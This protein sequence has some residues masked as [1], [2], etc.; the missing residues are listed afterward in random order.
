MKR[1]LI[2]LFF[3]TV[4]HICG[5]PNLSSKQ[6]HNFNER[7]FKDHNRLLTE[8]EFE[9]EF[10]KFVKHLGFKES[11][12]D[13]TKTNGF[14]C[15]G[16]WQFSY[17]TLQY[18]GYG[19]ITPSKFKKNPNIFPRD[20]QLKV[21]RELIAINDAYLVKYHEFIGT[22]INGIVITKSGLLAAIHLGG[23]TS[24]RQFL[25]SHGKIDKADAYGTKISRYIKE[26]SSYNI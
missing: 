12:N 26:F 1:I 16:E 4:F 22:K 6:S 7:L 20:L 2:T 15:I 3:L 14:S 17:S 23:I 5:A 25:V 11:T 8:K 9:K 19:Y 10:N 24:I 13:W 18:L 21:L